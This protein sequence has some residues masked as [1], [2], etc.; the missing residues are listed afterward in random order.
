MS[1]L[2]WWFA[3]VAVGI[4]CTH[5]SDDVP[6]TQQVLAVPT[7]S[8]GTEPVWIDVAIPAGPGPY[9]VVVYGHGQ[10]TSNLVNC[11]PDR[12]P[13]DVDAVDGESVAAALAGEGYLA[14]SIDY[15]NIG[16]QIPAI[17]EFRARDHYVFDASAFLA[18]AHFAHDQLGGTNEVAFI[19]VSMG[20]FP[21]TW[22]TAPLPELADL[23]AGLDVRTTIPTAM[24]GNQIGNTG[25]SKDTLASGDRETLALAALS[26]VLPRA[27]LALDPSI[28]A[29]DLVG[30]EGA[31]LTPAGVDLV[32]AEFLD[33]GCGTNMPAACS[34]TC[35]SSTFDTVA[36]AHGIVRI[37]P[38]DWMTDDTLDAIAYWS[39][40]DAIDP[41]ADTTNGM[42]AA[43][44]ALSP[45]YT[46]EGPLVA[47][48]V[49]PLVS[50]GDH[51]VTGQLGS[52]N[53]PALQY[54]DRVQATGVTMPD[55]LPV[56]TDTTCDHGNYLEPSR[57]Q[58]GWSLVLDELATAF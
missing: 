40:P 1:V 58:C 7:P 33:A 18:A 31:G 5:P 14:I 10:G 21:A 23:Q 37:D 45:A 11:A 34:A 8:G 20:S 4:G 9:P 28:T 35:A 16:A 39:P 24:L 55:P 42:L 49:F 41:G 53:A 12:A 56:V 30:P 46:L 3:A 48:R 43:M 17:G 52:S 47:A 2:P 19:G 13:D 22:A 38:R 50:R 57:P 25:R 29:D 54:L 27:A 44:R 6:A 36:S 32:R 15:R 51:V 26:S